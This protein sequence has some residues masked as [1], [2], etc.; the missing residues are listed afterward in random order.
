[1]SFR[2]FLS[3]TSLH[4]SPKCAGATDPVTLEDINEDDGPMCWPSDGN[5]GTAGDTCKRDADC[6]K[7][8]TIIGLV[9]NAIRNGMTYIINPF[10]KK[11][12]VDVEEIISTLD[13]EFPLEDLTNNQYESWMDYFNDECNDVE[14]FFLKA[15]SEDSEDSE[16]DDF[17]EDDL[18]QTNFSYEQENSPD[19]KFLHAVD[20]LHI[21]EVNLIDVDV[22]VN[23]GSGNK[24]AC[25]CSGNE[26]WTW[27]K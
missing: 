14:Q 7:G 22:I 18:F 5:G 27:S 23:D 11:I 25:S 6:Y 21:E 13:F 15:D 20:T 8:T 1:M 3:K 26:G 2:T 10:D 19:T 12:K 9:C 24:S 17:D 4:P 16:E